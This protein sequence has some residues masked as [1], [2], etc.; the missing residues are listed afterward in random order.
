MSAQTLKALNN[1]RKLAIEDVTLAIIKKQEPIRLDDLWELLTL[2]IEDLD[3]HE[4]RNTLHR[5]QIL[6]KVE[7]SNRTHI[8]LK[9]KEVK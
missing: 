1:I 3:A 9:R 7:V 2:Q 4:Y 6:E 8:V 5:L